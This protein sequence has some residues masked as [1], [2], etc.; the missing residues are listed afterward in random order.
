LAGRQ[1]TLR[2]SKYGYKLCSSSQKRVVHRIDPNRVQSNPGYYFG[3]KDWWGTTDIEIS[4]KELVEV[5]DYKDGRM[6]VDVKNN[7]QMIN[8]AIGRTAFHILDDHGVPD[9]NSELAASIKIILTIIQPKTDP[10]V[11]SQEMTV[12]EL[13][14]HAARL[15][16]AAAATDD[17]DAPLVAGKHCTWCKHGRAG[18]CTAK[19]AAKNEVA[20][21][22]IQMMVNQNGKATLL[23]MIQT[24]QVTT[25]TMT[26]KVLADVMD[27]APAIIALIKQVDK[28]VFDRLEKETFTDG[29][30]A[31]GTGNKSKAWAVLHDAKANGQTAEE[32]EES[33]TKLLKGMRFKKDEI[34]PPALVSP[35]QALKKA[36]LTERQKKKLMETM[37]IELPGKAKVV[38]SNNV[39][40]GAE[41]MFKDVVAPK[42]TKKL[43]F[44]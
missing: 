32:A 5:I 22:G 35:A 21:G 26:D 40:V 36:D 38:R 31:L 14:D 4:N 24:G 9:P 37:I 12:K 25:A 6:Y 28:E 20:A 39:Q 42:P 15:A 44:R 19:E 29:R 13:W 11:R 3:R 16:A 27:A 7:S 18:K 10:P 41:E 17:P 33:L 30:Y 2:T 8:N 23:E 34:R 1:G 43:S